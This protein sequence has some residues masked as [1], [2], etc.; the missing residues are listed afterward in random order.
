MSLGFALGKP[1]SSR[2]RGNGSAGAPTIMWI[3]DREGTHTDALLGSASALLLF[4]LLFS[5]VANC[6]NEGKNQAYVFV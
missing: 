2:T 6:G 1:P 3:V 5:L 4:F